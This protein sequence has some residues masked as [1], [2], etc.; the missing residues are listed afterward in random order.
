MTSL[1]TS[2]PLAP[3]FLPHHPGHVA[4]MAPNVASFPSFTS[5]PLLRAAAAQQ[6]IRPSLVFPMENNVPASTSGI[7][8]STAPSSVGIGGGIGTNIGGNIGTNIGGVSGSL[9]ALGE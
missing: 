2:S 9:A 8:V 7:V 4:A 5:F 1:L 6:I 3:T